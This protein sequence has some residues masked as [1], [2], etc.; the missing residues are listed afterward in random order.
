MVFSLNMSIVIVF[1]LI[2][3]GTN[4]LKMNHF[5]FLIPI[6]FKWSDILYTLANNLREIIL[7]F[8]IFHQPLG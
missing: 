4:M 5:Q 8:T 1:C 7:M 3:L 2:C 6:S